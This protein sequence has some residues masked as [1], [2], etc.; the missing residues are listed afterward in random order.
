MSA[1]LALAW[2]EE[3]LI[4]RLMAARPP[5]LHGRGGTDPFYG[6]PRTPDEVEAA[7]QRRADE[8]IIEMLR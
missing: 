6:D 1:R 5:D 3:A 2:W 7:I 8:A 4:E